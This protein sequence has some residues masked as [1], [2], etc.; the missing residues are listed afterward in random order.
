MICTCEIIININI[1]I[2][3]I[4]GNEYIEIQYTFTISGMKLPY[5]K[6]LQ[7]L[8]LML[9]SSGQEGG[10]LVH[11]E[12]GLSLWCSYGLRWD[13]VCAHHPWWKK[14]RWSSLQSSPHSAAIS[15]LMACS[16]Q[17][18]GRWLVRTLVVRTGGGKVWSPLPAQEV[19][20]LSP[21]N[22]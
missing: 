17:T 11:G 5:I 2:C 16:S 22:P 1:I 4:L 19:R 6:L 15:S 14:S 13:S 12:C 8:D 20:L 9:L 18:R 10:R 7:N 21:F 3:R